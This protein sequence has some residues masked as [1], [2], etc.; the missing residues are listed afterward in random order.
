MALTPRKPTW[1]MR[2]RLLW[3]K[4]RR[5]G[6]GLF[7]IG[8]VRR[9]AARREGDCQRCGACCQLG[10]RCQFLRNAK[11]I[12]ECR[13]HAL[14]PRNCRLFPIDERDLADRDLVAPDVPCGYRF[15]PRK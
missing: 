14:R 6:L 4:A 3:G 5:L 7:R 15:E 9:S 13:I 8:Y 2:L 10:Y 12:S 1:R 11:S